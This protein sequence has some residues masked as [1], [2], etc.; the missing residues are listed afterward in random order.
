[1]KIPGIDLTPFMP[2][3]ARGV[4]ALERMADAL[5]KIDDNLV[6]LTTEHDV[7]MRPAPEPWGSTEKVG[8]L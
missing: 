8:P 1:V 6:E 4:E 3:L 2:L 7:E 5:E